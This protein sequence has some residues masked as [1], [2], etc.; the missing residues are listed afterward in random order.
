MQLTKDGRR[1]RWI[2]MAFYSASAE[3]LALAKG[4]FS[5]YIYTYNVWAPYTK[6]L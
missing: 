5:L 4:A 1:W 3:N 2:E 6:Q